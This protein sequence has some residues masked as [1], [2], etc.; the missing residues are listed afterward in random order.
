ML[1]VHLK[2]KHQILVM[3]VGDGIPVFVYRAP[4]YDMG[5]LISVRVYLPAPVDKR[6]PALGGHDGIEH[7]GEIAAGRI[8][9]AGRNVHAADSHAVMLVLHRARSDGYVREKI[10]QITPVLRIEHLIR[11]SQSRLFNGRGVKLSS[12]LRCRPEDPVSFRDP[13]GEPAP[14]I[15]F[16]WYA[17]YS[18]RSGESG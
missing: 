4:E 11:G 10:V 12:W 16:P 2:Q 3:V 8:F 14:C 9:H 15:P 5:Y 6:M 13:A 7:H 18:Y 1:P 17:A